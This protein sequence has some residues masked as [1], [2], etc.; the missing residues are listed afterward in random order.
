MI[1][2]EFR[3]VPLSMVLSPRVARMTH[4]QFRFAVLALMNSSERWTLPFNAVHL[5]RVSDP[6]DALKARPEQ[7]ANI[8]DAF[9]CPE[10]G[11]FIRGRFGA[12]PGLEI[13]PEF[14]RD[15]NNARGAPPAQMEMVLPSQLHVLPP[16]NSGLR[17]E[18]NKDPE[19][20]PQATASS[21][22][23]NEAKNREKGLQKE[24]TPRAPKA[25]FAKPIEDIGSTPLGKR[26]I[27][28]IGPMHM[29]SECLKSGAEWQRILRDEAATLADVLE[30]GERSRE[31]MPEAKTRAKFVTARLGQR[32]S[33]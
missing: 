14:R 28:F 16:A 6:T 7:I 24:S 1:Q 32:R 22:R 13:A 29:I 31:T 4:F 9:L 10:L 20:L 17:T 30:Q 27:A 26:L 2:H 25:R 33:A 19:S 11:F 18:Q 23:P 12:E 8:R 3:C 15:A 21:S 5:L